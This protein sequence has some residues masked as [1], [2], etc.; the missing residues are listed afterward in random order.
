MRKMVQFLM[1]E[2]FV[3][4]SLLC[5]HTCHRIHPF[6]EHYI[7]FLVLIHVLVWNMQ[8]ALKQTLQSDLRQQETQ[9][10]RNNQ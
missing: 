6:L 10:L 5:L 7:N 1:K 8:T 2:T 3:H 4:S 9:Y